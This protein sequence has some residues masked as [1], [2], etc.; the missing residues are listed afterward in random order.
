[1]FQRLATHIR[2]Q[3]DRLIDQYD[4][5][6]HTVPGYANLPGPARRDLERRVL[7]IM[8]DCLEANDDNRLIQYVRERAE[9]VL[10]HGF[11]PEWFQQAIA[12][13]QEIIAPLVET[14]EESNFVWRSQAHAQTA[15]WEIVARE[16][17]RVELTLRESDARY[18]TIFDATPIMF[19]LKDT[20]N[21]TLRINKA[22]AELEG[23]TP[24]D[25]EGRSAYDLYPHEQAEAFFQD[26]LEVI[27]TNRPKLGIVEQH[28]SVGTGRLMWLETGKTPVRDDQ[29]EVVGVLAFAIDVTERQQAEDNLRRSA[30]QQQRATRRLRAVLDAASE[31][32]Q[33]QDLATLYRRAVEL[34]R[35]KLE[36]ER[37][38][39]FMIDE[40]RSF[41]RGT[42]GTSDQRRTTDERGARRELGEF[43]AILTAG[44][45]QLW[46]VR[47]TPHVFVR[48][49]VQHVVGAGWVGATVLRGAAG[50]LG[51][52]F[53][54]CALSGRPVDEA[55]QESLAVYCSIIGSIIERRHLEE[56][57]QKSFVRRGIQVQT[58]TEVAQEIAS[59]TDLPELFRRVVTL[60]KERFNYYHAQLFRYEPAQDAVV[61]ITGYGEIGQKMLAA[62]HKLPMGRGVVGTAA[63]TGRSILATDVQ[64]DA[65]WRPNPHLP[66]TQGEL[67]VPIK[68]R[69]QMLGILDVQSDRAGVLTDDDRLLLEG[70]CGQIATA[71]ESKRVEQELDRSA[72]LLRLIINT[73]RDLIYV[74]DTES[75]FLVASQA[76][77]RLLGA[78]TAA[79]LIGKTDYDFF[80]YE[81]AHK[82]YTDEQRIIQTGEPLIGAE[83]PSAYPDGTRIWL[84]TTKTPYRSPD[85]EV[86]GTVG[87]GRDITERRLAEES[88]RRN[89]AQLSNALKIAQLG[90]WEYDAGKDLFTFNDQFYSIFHTTAEQAGGYQL[91]SA[92]YAQ[93]FVH[94]GDR[95]VVGAEIE[96]ALNSA[97]Q[98]Y[99]RQ[100][101]YRILYADGGVG[102]VAVN[103]NVD[104]DAQGRILHY[105][106]AAQDITRQKL[107]EQEFSRF[108]QGLEQASDAVFMTDVDGRIIYVNPAFVKIYGYSREE[109]LG[110]TPRILKSGQLAPEFYQDFWQALLHKQSVSGEKP[111][112]TKDGRVIIVEDSNSPIVDSAG[113]L[114]GFLSTHRDIT[115]R[116]Q[117]EQRMAETLRETERLY[118]A[119]S[120]ESWQAYRQTGSLGQGYLFDRALIQPADQLWEPEIPEALQQQSLVTSHSEQRALAVAPLSVRGEAIGVFGVYDDPAQPLSTEDLQLIEAVSEQVALALES[121][122]LFDQTERDAVREHTINRVTTRIRNARS[123]DE[124]LSIAA[125]ELR[126]ATRASRSLVEILPAA[127]E[128]ARTGN[129]HEEMQRP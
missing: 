122:R 104:R 127:E 111:N 12:L 47:E 16:R 75:R 25:V 1:M 101:E 32:I 68:W 86:E 26:D 115:E 57:V 42:F 76:V 51:I 30:E 4:A 45:E 73:S 125:Q 23:V 54:D 96:Q 15:A 13:P 103:I 20:H 71:M 50:L 9:Q 24:A 81:L 112:R 118:A 64:Q 22:A 94:P 7:Q 113:A 83:E 87:I 39:L 17:R 70:L 97:G 89:E 35:E 31:L 129:G 41:L 56:Q 74:K 49:G 8:A 58:S 38:G 33:I 3:L 27:R 114:L 88:L 106:G 100:L 14:V 44:P 21:R 72:T 34:A 55:Q 66:H 121:A 29:G 108:K 37:C 28:T 65:D 85:G 43:S 63:L 18:Q 2:E 92:Q 128:T 19:W 40:S 91:S 82:Y 36:I 62:G 48:D 77:A 69:D 126:L 116:K 109:A 102:Y 61:L 123:V 84:L 119:V 90:Y 98:H 52:L 11:E 78:P 105:Y 107:V 59:A 60:I 99:H 120:H 79:D 53:N 46:V 10:L 95:P 67:A 124:V 117:A 93:Q 110:Q 5:R 6:L 80:P